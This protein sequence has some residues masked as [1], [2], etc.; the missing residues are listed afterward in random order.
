[1][2]LGG[3]GGRG[4]PSA[5][6]VVFELGG[7]GGRGQPSAVNVRSIVAGLPAERLT[8]RITGST[9]NT[10]KAETANIIAVFFKVVSLLTYRVR[11]D[12]FGEE[13]L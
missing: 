11:R 4:Q 8:D 3:P 13:L 7:P 5:T 6:S 10:A 9:I 12:A 1:M 2:E